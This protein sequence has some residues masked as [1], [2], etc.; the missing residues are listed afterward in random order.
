MPE[1]E[2]GCLCGATRYR[3]TGRPTSTMI[4][5]CQTCRRAAG[6]PDVAWV[7]F[8]DGLPVFQRSRKG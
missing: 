5:H 8:G 2:G 4:C 7:R 3:A 6:S 1:I